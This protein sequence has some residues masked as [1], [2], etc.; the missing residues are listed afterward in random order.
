VTLE[1]LGNIGDFVGGIAV[2]VTLVYLALQIRQNTRQIE[3]AVL[4][5]QSTSYHES[6]Q[7]GWEAI[8]EVAKDPEFAQILAKGSQDLS[9]LSEEE[10]VRMFALFSPILSSLEIQLHLHESGQIHRDLWDMAF[11]NSA[12]LLS[13]PGVLELVRRRRG[14]LSDRLYALLKGESAA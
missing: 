3:H 12:P 9:T 7:Q 4:A 6:A 10:R 11:L 8:L 14:P 1:A 5:S 2:V 13:S